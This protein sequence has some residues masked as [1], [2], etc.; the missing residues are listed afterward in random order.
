MGKY[1]Y[2]I[3]PH[4]GRLQRILSDEYIQSLSGEGDMKKEVYD[5]NEDGIV[6]NSEKLEGSTKSEVQDHEPKEHT[7]TESEITDLEHDAQKIKGKEIDDSAID[8]DKYL[9]YDGEK[10][11][12]DTPSGGGQP[13]EHEFGFI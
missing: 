1:K 5:T 11:V 8:T 4:T 9:K 3:N 6:D 7:H 10:I 2:V 13:L 12:Y